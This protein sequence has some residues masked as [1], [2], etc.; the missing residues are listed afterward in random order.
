MT[1]DPRRLL[2]LLA[3]SDAGG[4]GK[5]A[6]GLGISQPALSKSLALLER[7]VGVKLFDRSRQGA[8]LTTYG[9]LLVERSR[10]LNTLMEQAG[11]DLQRAIAGLDGT[12]RI[13]VSPVGCVAVVPEAVAQLADEAPK[14]SIIVR[15]LSDQHLLTLL[16]RGELDIVVSPDPPQHDREGI[17]AEPLFQ[18][19]LVVAVGRDSSLANQKSLSLKQIS[20]CRFAMPAPETAMYRTIESLFERGRAP[21]PAQIVFCGSV[22]LIKSLVRNNDA[23]TLISDRMIDPDVSMGWIR[24]IPLRGRAEMRQISIRRLTCTE[25]TPLVQRFIACLQAQTRP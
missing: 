11:A 1:I 18:D 5:A 16:M 25:P 24:G 10:A 9:E 12:I 4:F 2:Q 13:G 14:A 21:L 22:L 17:H 15:E 7:E 6:R 20:G 8:S 23:V 19:R 3:V